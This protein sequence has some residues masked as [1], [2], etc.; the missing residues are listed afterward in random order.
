[1]AE[2]FGGGGGVGGSLMFHVCKRVCEVYLGGW[3][4]RSRC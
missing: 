1:M 4:M 3:M 2:V